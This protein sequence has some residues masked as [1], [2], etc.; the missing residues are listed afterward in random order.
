MGKN[1]LMQPIVPIYDIAGNFASGKAAGLGNNTNPLKYAS[2][3]QFDRNVN[4]RAIGNVFGSFAIR[5]ALAV[6]SQFSF[7]LGQSQFT[8][9]TPIAP[10]EAEAKF[11]N[12]IAQNDGRSTSWT[13]TNTMTYGRTFAARHN[14][15]L[16]LGQEA[17]SSTGRF[18]SGGISGLLND[19]VA[20]RY[21][22]ESLGQASTKTVSSSGYFD[23][24][25]SFFGKADYNYAERYYASVTVR[26]DG[27]SKFAQGHKWGT[28][29]AFNVGW[30]LSRESFFPQDGFFSNVMLRFGYG[31]TGNQ[32]IPGGRIVAK[33]GGGTGDTFYD[34]GGSGSSILPGFRQIALGNA[35]LQWEEQKSGNVGVDLEFLHGRGNFTADVYNRTTDKLLFD[36]RAPS[37]AG[38]ANPAIQNIGKMTRSGPKSGA[39][40]STAAITRTRLSRSTA[41]SVSSPVRAARKSRASATRS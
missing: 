19:A 22:D 24:L 15:N 7:N 3:R 40:R 6:R 13:F 32:N 10:E 25:L 30:R 1:I 38:A 2:G 21:I 16:L 28:F 14:L 31:V 12:S 18:L 29:P 26:R 41:R 34:I 39:S 36:P 23:R 33:F 37:T 27:S 11:T 5:P 8:G 20:D 9:F 17:N 35:N 4:D